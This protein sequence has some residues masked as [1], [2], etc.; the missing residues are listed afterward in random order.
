MKG[1]FLESCERLSIQ[2][3][4]LEIMPNFYRQSV[5]THHV[6]LV[7]GKIPLVGI[8]GAD[9]DNDAFRKSIVGIP[10]LQHAYVHGSLVVAKAFAHIEVTHGLHLYIVDSVAGFHINVGADAARGQ[11]RLDNM[12][13]VR[14]L[15]SLDINAKDG[16]E[17]STTNAFVRHD[18]A[19][20]WCVGKLQLTIAHGCSFDRRETTP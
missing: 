10:F 5:P 1:A 3:D 6:E 4:P 11:S 15:D 9:E 17:H 8:I 19:E 18:A 7:Y 20:H 2:Y 14:V 13:D 16:L 12:L